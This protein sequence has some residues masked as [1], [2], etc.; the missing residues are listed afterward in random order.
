M[1]KPAD[2]RLQEEHGFGDRTDIRTW[3]DYHDV[4]EGRLP[5]MN[6]SF[7]TTRVES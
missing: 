2:F 4:D 5:R 1:P 7:A 6:E 3:V